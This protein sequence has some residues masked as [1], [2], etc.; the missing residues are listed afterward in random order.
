MIF[1]DSYNDKQ[2][3]WH[4]SYPEA[5]AYA[6]RNQYI[7]HLGKPRAD[8][9]FLNKASVTDPQVGTVYS[10]Q[11]LIDAGYT[12]TYLSPDNFN[13]TSARVANGLLAPEAPAYKAMVVTG[14]QNVTL[15]AVSS[16]S[17]LH[18]MDYPSSL[19]AGYLAITPLATPATRRQSCRSCKI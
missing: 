8:V 6:S 4:H 13:M 7:L 12:Y 15:D 17:N 10:G 3:A 18:R 5:I 9:A 11:D 19:A 1:S 2:P 16:S 14:H